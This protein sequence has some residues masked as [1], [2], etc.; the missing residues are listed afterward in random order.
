MEHCPHA[1]A[2]ILNYIYLDVC[3]HISKDIIL[4]REEALLLTVKR[5]HVDKIVQ[6]VE[7]LHLCPLVVHCEGLAESLLVEQDSS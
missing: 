7:G 5:H 4:G 1:Q 6:V 3:F 2:P